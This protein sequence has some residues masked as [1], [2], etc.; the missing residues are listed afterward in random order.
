MAIR[1]IPCGTYPTYVMNLP[2]TERWDYDG[3]GNMIYHGMALPGSLTS[4]AVWFIEKY[5]YNA[6]N[7]PTLHELADGNDLPDNIWDSRSSIAYA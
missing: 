4:D 3:G 2:I 1:P 5:T 6:S 7:Q